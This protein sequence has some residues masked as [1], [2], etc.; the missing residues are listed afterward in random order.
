LLRGN[1]S[2]FTGGFSF[3][4]AAMLAPNSARQLL[5]DLMPKIGKG[6]IRKKPEPK[7]PP[8]VYLKF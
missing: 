5:A 3:S 7:S 8:K 1:P 2:D 6:T 4:A